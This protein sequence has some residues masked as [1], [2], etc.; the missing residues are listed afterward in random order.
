MGI[1]H[2]LASF[3]LAVLLSSSAAH[4]GTFAVFG[5]RDYTRGTGQ[6]QPILAT[7]TSQQAAPPYT[8]RIING[9][10]TGT[11]SKV[12][13]AIVKINGVEIFGTNDFKSSG[14][15][16]LEKIVT[17]TATNEISVEIRSA[18]GDGMTISVLGQGNDGPVIAAT[19][20]PAPNVA[21]WNSDIVTVTFA[22]SAAQTGITSCTAPVTVTAEGTTE[23]T[24]TAIDGAGNTATK[25]VSVKIDKTPP[26]LAIAAPAQDTVVAATS[27]NISGSSSDALAGVESVLCNGEPATLNGSSFTCGVTM[28]EGA[29]AIT[30]VATDR[31]ENAVLLVLDIRSDITPPAI[32]IESPASGSTNVS[33]LTVSGSVTD[34]DQVASVQIAGQPATLAGGAFSGTV[35]LANGASTIPVKAT[36]RAGNHATTS[37][38]ITRYALP[39]V[40]IT[41]PADLAIERNAVITVS[42]TVT[43]ASSV[44]VNGI[45]AAVANG[46]FTASGVPLAQ[47][48]TVITAKGTSDSGSVATST[49]LVYRD[50]IPPRVVL[51]Y[52]L[53][54][55][56]VGQP[57]IDVTGMVDD[58]VV[59]TIN[60]AQMSVRVNDVQAEVA[61]R[62]FVAKG[63][64]LTPGL[65]TIRVVG[66]DQGGNSVTVTATVNYDNSAQTKIAVVSGDDQTGLVGAMLAAPIAVKVT[67][68]GIPVSGRMVTFEVVENNGTLTGSNGTDRIVSAATDSTGTASVRWTLGTRAGAGNQR[69][70]A[71]AS[72]VARGIQFSASGQTG[73]PGGIVVD[74]GDAQYGAVGAPLPR[75]LV[76][77]VIDAGKNR[78]AGVPVTFS[79]LQGTGHF[80]GQQQVT[81]TSDSDGRAWATPTLGQASMN[82]FQANV[83]GITNGSGFQAFGKVAG[84]PEQTSISGVILDNTDLPVP[85]VTVRIE[86]TTLVAQ[87]SNEGQFTIPRAPVGYVKL[88]VDGSTSLRPGTWPTLEYA[89]YTISGASNTLEMPIHILPLDVRRGLFV[90]ETTG[91]TLTLPELP[92]FS[93]TVKPGSA[94]FPGGGRT[95]IVS[96]TMVHADKVPMSPGFGQQPR[97]IITIQPPGVHFDPPAPMT[98]P[99]VDSMEPGSVTEMYSF[100]HDLGQFVSIG[101]ASVSSDGMV[102]GSDPGVGIIKGGW[103]CGGNPIH[104]GTVADCPTCRICLN[105]NCNNVYSGHEKRSSDPDDMCC[106]GAFFNKKSNCC[107]GPAPIHLVGK[108]FT[109]FTDCPG[110]VP[111]KAFPANKVPPI[112]NYN[113]CSIPDIPFLTTSNR[114][115]PVYGQYTELSGVVQH[116]EYTGPQNGNYMLPCDA[117]DECY[118]R[119]NPSSKG[120]CES[121]MFQNI[122]SVC[123]YAELSGEDSVTVANCRKWADKIRDG[124]EIAGTFAFMSNQKKAC[125]C[126][127]DSSNP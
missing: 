87:A 67:N 110:W 77:V 94:T 69:V 101:T 42:G 38:Q 107:G 33:T 35:S 61:N 32:T 118:Q 73:V 34:G 125:L 47:G 126:C 27:A 65:N 18:P 64:S 83:A 102:I 29:N 120:I 92:G 46:T 19:V 39:A 28:T 60:S 80:D 43:D 30:L 53:D 44:E 50:S 11:F 82:V 58:I 76:A 109:G 49:I 7:F 68:N 99:N 56:I 10:A 25:T 89:M 52:P 117:H 9:G 111:D 86:G 79:V 114:N 12:T 103:H 1:A 124:L 22:C 41:A 45:H 85:G 26:A 75:P 66:T 24:G 91:G 63:I 105:D 74:S 88:I 100:D 106:E 6:P 123:N 4:A 71:V 119:C 17:L 108:R 98:F 70:T 2:R 55:A 78:L 8:L 96:V 112:F 57:S 121:N 115:N 3:G 116:G 14:P 104:N 51:R 72:G 21:G 127:A 113:G 13:S 84:A 48:R 81:V 62:A 36:D 93:L 54:G 20:T 122:M 59:G 90:D 37:L 23:V 31:A 97:F 5:P 16:I 40:A 95:G 15:V